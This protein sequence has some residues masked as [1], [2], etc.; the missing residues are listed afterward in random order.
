MVIQLLLPMALLV[1]K[2]VQAAVNQ[3]SILKMR[4]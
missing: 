1:V 4:L 2:V 3:R